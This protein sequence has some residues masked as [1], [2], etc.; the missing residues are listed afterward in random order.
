MTL[1]VAEVA[2]L[3]RQIVGRTDAPVRFRGVA[4]T[5]AGSHRVEVLVTIAG[6]VSE[7]PRLALLNVSREGADPLTAELMAKLRELS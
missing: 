7:Q 4:S 1:D 3:A 2:R 6:G 5:G